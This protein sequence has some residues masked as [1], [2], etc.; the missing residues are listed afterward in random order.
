MYPKG[1]SCE[2]ATFA[3]PGKREH[4]PNC[5]FMTGTLFTHMHTDARRNTHTPSLYRKATT[6]HIHH[7]APQ[8]LESRTR[9]LTAF[10]GSRRDNR[11]GHISPTLPV[12]AP[13]VSLA[14]GKG[15]HGDGAQH[16]SHP[17]VR[18]QARKRTRALTSLDAQQYRA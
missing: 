15:V 7:N 4:A 8:E 14:R 1:A 9:E 5:V 2:V 18:R 6:H 12:P 13:P 10:A 11:C 17:D 16:V 3:G